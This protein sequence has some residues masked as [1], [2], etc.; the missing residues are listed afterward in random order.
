MSTLPSKPLEF[1]AKIGVLGK[2][3]SKGRLKCPPH[4]TIPFPAVFYDYGPRKGELSASE[5]GPSPYVGLVDLSQLQSKSRSPS[6]LPKPE[7]EPHL[8]TPKRSSRQRTHHDKKQPPGTYRIPQ[9][10]QIQIVI[11]NPNNTAVKLFLVPYDLTGMAAGQKTFLR[12]RSYSAGPIVDIPPGLRSSNTLEEVGTG[13]NQRNNRSVLRYLIHIH[14]CC[15]S[16]GRFYLYKNIRVVFANRVPDGKEK[17]R[18]EIQLPE[19]RYTAYKPDTQETESIPQVAS[20]IKRHSDA[21]DSPFDCGVSAG[22]LEFALADSYSPPPSI[23]WRL[24]PPRTLLPPLDI[25]PNVT[26]STSTQSERMVV[27]SASPK[28]HGLHD[29]EP[30]VSHVY[31]KLSHED[32]GSPMRTQSPQPGEGLI[33][34]QFRDWVAEQRRSGSPA[35]RYDSDPVEDE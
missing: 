25:K 2:G 33:A 15:P 32:Y 26:R 31:D 10:G 23:P 29:T 21:S 11:K 24:P 12:Q 16:Q 9:Q 30:A 27:D 3:K 17:L 34:L 18:N 7:V 28:S 5:E 13:F 1:V 14:I 22:G 20:L 6:P 8:S 4:V 35:S 19:P